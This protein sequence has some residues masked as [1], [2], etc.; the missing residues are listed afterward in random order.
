MKA[1]VVLLVIG[2]AWVSACAAPAPSPS[3]GASGSTDSAPP[4]RSTGPKRMTIAIRSDPKALT[5][6]LNS[7]AGAGGSPG[8]PEI[9]Q[10]LNSGLGVE[11]KAGAIMPQLAEAVPSAENGLWQVFP[12]G[13]M[14]TR[15]RIRDGAAW[16]DG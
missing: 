2:I 10:M 3:G 8:A 1:Q 5:A 9:E 15:Y 13:R 12:D 6:K 7:A 16:H 4:A 14:E 11:T